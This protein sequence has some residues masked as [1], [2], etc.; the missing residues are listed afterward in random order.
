ML[1]TVP[2]PSRLRIATRPSCRAAMT[3]TSASPMPVPGRLRA[4][5][6]RASSCQTCPI[7]SAGMPAPV[8]AT[9]RSS[10]SSS[11]LA[12]TST[13][14]PGAE[15][16]TAL[17][18]RFWS[19]MN[20]RSR[21]PSMSGSGHGAR[22]TVTLMVRWLAGDLGDRLGHLVQQAG[23]VDRRR[24]DLLGLQVGQLAQVTD[25][26]RDPV[27]LRR[28]AGQGGRGAVGGRGAGLVDVREPGTD[29]GQRVLQLM[30]EPHQEAQPVLGGLG[31]GPPHR[32]VGGRGPGDSGPPARQRDGGQDTGT[33][34]PRQ[35][36]QQ[37]R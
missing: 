5:R 23:Q 20:S 11:S 34:Q 17:A 12:R 13:V 9:S 29:G 35:A 28:H 22:G 21:S 24:L 4:A 30:V 16:L 15:N 18:T 32:G 1:T 14:S 10:P 31:R 36:G 33:E 7:S 2:W 26:P 6:P 8:S 19:A 27:G 25:Q 37:A 3:R